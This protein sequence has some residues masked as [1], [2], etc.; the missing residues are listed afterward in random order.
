MVPAW[1]FSLRPRSSRS[2]GDGVKVDAIDALIPTLRRARRGTRTAPLSR[3]SSGREHVTSCPRRPLSAYRRRTRL[4]P[5]L[6]SPGRSPAL[7]QTPARPEN[8]HGWASRRCRAAR[9]TRP[10]ARRRRRL[11]RGRADHPVRGG[12]RTSRRRRPAFACVEIKFQAPHAI[13]AFTST[14]VVATTRPR[15]SLSSRTRRSARSRRLP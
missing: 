5:G 12:V 15:S 6:G 10:R 13:D 7:Q 9:T 11:L 14:P 4:A 3:Q 1:I 2:R 8:K